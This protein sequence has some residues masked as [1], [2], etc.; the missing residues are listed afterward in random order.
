MSTQ[1]ATIRNSNRWDTRT[2]VTMALLAAI[3]AALTFVEVGG[4]F[5][6]MKYDP[7]NVPAILAG[8]ALG[9]VQG[10]IVGIIASLVHMVMVSDF[11]GCLMNAVAVV[12]FVLISACIYHR[13]PSLKS[14]VVGLVVACL[15]NPFVMAGLGLIV[16]PIYTGWPVEQVL[17]MIVPVV[18]PFN[19]GKS[20]A[21]AVL[22]L[23][24]MK[25]LSNLVDAAK[26]K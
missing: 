17:E 26:A 19:L 2:L 10:A 21:N 12:I 11:W 24:L 15:V 16:T 25:P 23:L 13:A 4:F 8:F 14:A 6:F 9:P 1:T 22:A 18:L 7:S 20:A 5:G 3:G